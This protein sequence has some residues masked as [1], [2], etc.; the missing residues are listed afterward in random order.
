MMLSALS[1]SAIIYG[2][3]NIVS[4]KAYNFLFI[5]IIHNPMILSVF[6][7]NL[8]MFDTILLGDI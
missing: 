8:L 7:S 4:E 1:L 6:F 3:T 2:W 5:F